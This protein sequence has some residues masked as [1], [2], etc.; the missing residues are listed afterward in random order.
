MTAPVSI[1]VRR[2]I[3][4]GWDDEEILRLLRHRKAVAVRLHIHNIRNELERA[5]VKKTG[6]WP[7]SY[8]RSDGEPVYR[9]GY[10]HDIPASSLHH[11]GF[12]P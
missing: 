11:F 5:P 10:G 2:L 12:T 6:P 1:E 3:D 9:V 8:V 7:V 4:A